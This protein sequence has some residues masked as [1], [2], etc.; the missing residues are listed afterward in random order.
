MKW[1]NLFFM[2]KCIICNRLLDKKCYKK[3]SDICAKCSFLRKYNAKYFKENKNKEKIIKIIKE[4][5]TEKNY[6]FFIIDE[7]KKELENKEKDLHFFDK[8]I[9]YI[10]QKFVEKYGFENAFFIFIISII[11]TI[12]K[13]KT[14]HNISNRIYFLNIDKFFKENKYKYKSELF[15]KEVIFI[16]KKNN[17]LY[18]FIDNKNIFYYF[19]DLDII[20]TY[21]LYF[22]YSYY[23]IYSSYSSLE[24][25]EKRI[26]N[27]RFLYIRDHYELKE[28]EI[29]R[30]PGCKKKNIFSLL[31][32]KNNRYFKLIKE[33]F[34]YGKEE[35]LLFIDRENKNF[36]IKYLKYF[37]D[38]K[39]DSK[40]FGKYGFI[41]EKQKTYQELIDIL[42]FIDNNNYVMVD[43]F[44]YQKENEC[45]KDKIK[46]ITENGEKKGISINNIEKDKIID[47]LKYFIDYI[48][49]KGTSSF[50]AEKKN[51]KVEENDNELKN[52]YLYIRKAIS[53]IINKK[54]NEF[55]YY[56]KIYEDICNLKDKMEKLDGSIK[57]IKNN[58]EN[59]KLKDE[60]YIFN[61]KIDKNSFPTSGVYFLIRGNRII[62]I[63]SSV[64]C[65]VRINS[66]DIKNFD[67]FVIIPY[68]EELLSFYE[69]E[70]IF[71]FAPLKNRNIPSKNNKNI[72]YIGNHENIKNEEKIKDL[73]DKGII[74]RIGDKY[75]KHK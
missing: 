25:Y 39:I 58:I 27:N 40:N 49:Y 12:S 29:I 14:P 66:H 30:G 10:H 9:Y 74:K 11:F 45:R 52:I 69:S 48:F 37:S 46:K 42:F 73:I 6:E 63:G 18:E 61:N 67:Y 70:Y 1:N 17:I 31:E 55:E 5:I 20:N 28:L 26:N 43:A 62:Y 60:D 2:K 15:I 51:K 8:W 22:L 65:I 50:F 23:S 7:I 24:E 4:K 57:K 68:E 72:K 54:E 13:H 32:N 21:K 3:D 41:E 56:K 16:L 75:Y 53:K 71:K 19:K 33:N 36:F 64:N 59:K 35:Y 38:E 44:Y 34:I 47:H